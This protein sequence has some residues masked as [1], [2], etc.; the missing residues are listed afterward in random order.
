MS[1]ILLG[2][3]QMQQWLRNIE[4]SELLNQLS[5]SGADFIEM[6]LLKKELETQLSWMNMAWDRGLKTSFHAPYFAE[7]ELPCFEAKEGNPVREAYYS[8][9]SKIAEFCN[10]KGY[11]GRVNLHAA[12]SPSIPHSDLMSISVEFF[13]WLSQER[14]KNGWDLE[15]VV[16][17]LPVNKAT[18]LKIG[19]KTS[20][21]LK[22]KEKLGSVLEGF[23]W[24]LGHYQWNIYKYG[25]SDVS[26]A[27]YRNIRHVHVHDFKEMTFGMDHCPLKFGLVPWE[28]YLSKLPK[29]GD[30]YI[31]LELDFRN[32]QI[33]G[34]AI[35]E[36]LDSFKK[37]KYIKAKNIALKS[38]K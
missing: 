1:K 20:D 16:E 22:L 28:K 18:K 19:Q 4:P 2:A 35:S 11:R 24:D 21:L 36:L 34:E 30:I 38:P 25:K 10:E 33:C 37:M 29:K 12:T 3:G 9:F 23:C 14:E 26:S 7:Y 31:V 5:Y 15:Y 17:L 6:I 8:L 32:T 13:N 27:F